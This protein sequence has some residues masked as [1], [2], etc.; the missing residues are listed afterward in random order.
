MEDSVVSKDIAYQI[1]FCLDQSKA[2]TNEHNK[3]Q[4]EGHNSLLK[5]TKTGVLT[6]LM[7]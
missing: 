6:L 3:K 2:K 5:E 1:N 7:S 4:L